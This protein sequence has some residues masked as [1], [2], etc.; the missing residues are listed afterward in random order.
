MKNSS[1]L[2]KSGVLKKIFKITHRLVIF[3]SLLLAAVFAFYLAGSKNQFLD[4][5]LMIILNIMSGAA[6][7]HLAFLFFYAAQIAVL[8]ALTRSLSFL[9][10]VCLFAVSFAASFA[11]ALF[12]RALILTSSG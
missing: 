5:T 11:L 2:G 6:M 12:S 4:G 10:H 9:P 3:F 7:W 8:T 1:R